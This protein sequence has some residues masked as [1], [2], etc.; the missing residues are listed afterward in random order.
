MMMKAIRRL[1]VSTCALIA[2]AL[3]AAAQDAG[4]VLRLSVGYNTLKNSTS[5]SAEKRAEVE[6][7]GKLAQ[8]ASAARKYGDALKHYYH[9]IALMRGSEWTPARALSTALTVKL[10]RA[11]V[12]PS[13]TIR[14]EIG[15]IFSLDE[16]PFDKLV[17]TF[18][19][20]AMNGAAV[21]VLKTV[22]DAPSD[23]TAKPF[24]T[25]VVVPDIEDGKYRL[26]VAFKSA[27]SDD[28]AAM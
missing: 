3:S 1:A 22:E 20:N 18:T 21:K 17:A 11:V 25:E 24:V 4:Q 5:M 7:L 8:Q 23:F 13:N 16:K 12:E 28:E 19:L 2:L 15:Q 10:D 14:V 6:R 9:A 27:P 26:T